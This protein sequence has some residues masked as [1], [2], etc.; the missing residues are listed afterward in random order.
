VTG[1]L[2]EARVAAGPGVRVIVGGGGAAALAASLQGALTRGAGAVMSFGIAG[3]L[4]EDLASGA[5]VI[6]RSVVSPAA[7]WPCDAAWVRNLAGRLPGALTAD[8]AGVDEPITEPAAKRALQRATGAAAVD[9]E[10]HIAAALAAA[11]GV[12][13]AAFRVVADSAR[14]M[15]PP[16]ALVALA[17][18]GRIRGAAVLGSLARTPA[19]LPSLLRTAIDA[20]TA[21]RALSR[22]RRLLGP[23]LAYPDS[24]ELVLDVS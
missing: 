11:H 23:G 19:Q 9:T 14:R 3:G 1:L 5:W 2:V 7:R 20:G 22:G 13:F 12:P 8:L 21:L 6:A 24:S 10:S 17:A 15:L 18:D 16:A 4:A